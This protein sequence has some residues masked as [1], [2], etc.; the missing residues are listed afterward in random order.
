[1][2]KVHTTLTLDDGVK[3]KAKEVLDD[4]GIDLSTTVNILLRKIARE[5]RIPFELTLEVPNAETMKAIREGD[6][7]I[8]VNHYESTEDMFNALGIKT[9]TCTKSV[10]PKRLK[11]TL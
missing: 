4:L 10:Q 6:Q 8:N 3:E 5:R 9:N 11:K 2:A 7:G 1:M